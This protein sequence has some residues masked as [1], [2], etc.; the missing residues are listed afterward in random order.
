LLQW[1]DIMKKILFVLCLMLLLVGCGSNEVSVD[2]EEAV[3]AEAPAEDIEEVE[4]TVVVADDSNEGDVSDVIVDV[5]RDTPDPITIELEVY[6]FGFD[7]NII[8]V[9]AGQE[10]T[11]IVSSQDTGHS[12]SI[13]SLRIHIE[14]QPG[15]PGEQTFTVDEPGEYEWDCDVYCG[16]GHGD[17]HGTLVVT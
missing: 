1:R 17:M 10:V 11:L 5:E 6:Q 16:S 3:V 14:A 2:V 13:G 4:D 12:L 7:P 15:S 9:Q 8:E